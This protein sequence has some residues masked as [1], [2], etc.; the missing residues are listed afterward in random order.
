MLVVK[1]EQRNFWGDI[2]YKEDTKYNPTYND[3]KK[4]FRFLKKD[5]KNAIQI[6]NTIL[7]WDSISN[8]EYGLLDA[9]EYDDGRNYK[10]FSWDY[11]GCK[12]NYYNIYKDLNGGN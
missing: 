3:I 11:D 2:E 7:Y 5:Y 6:N 4:A 1:Y 12:N 10:E 8:F 9:R